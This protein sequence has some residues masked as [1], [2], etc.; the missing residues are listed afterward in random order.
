MITLQTRIDESGYVRLKQLPAPSLVWD[1]ALI[2][3]PRN[4]QVML[5][6]GFIIRVSE[7]GLLLYYEISTDNGLTWTEPIRIFDFG[8]TKLPNLDFYMDSDGIMMRLFFN[9]YNIEFDRWDIWQGFLPVWMFIKDLSNTYFIDGNKMFYNGVNSFNDALK[10]NVYQRNTSDNTKIIQPY[11]KYPTGWTNWEKVG[12]DKLLPVAA[13]TQF[14]LV[15]TDPTINKDNFWMRDIP[16]TGTWTRS[17][18]EAIPLEVGECR[19]LANLPGIERNNAVSF[20]IGT[21]GYIGTGKTETGER[22]NDLWQFDSISGAWKKRAYIFTQREGASAFSIA[23]KGYLVGGIDPDSNILS[24][25]WK[26][27]ET[28]NYWTQ[29]ADIP[30]ARKQAVSFVIDNKAYIATGENGLGNLN[31]LYSYDPLT[32]EWTRKADLPGNARTGA[33]GFSILRKGYVCA[34]DSGSL[35]NDLWEYDPDTDS[36]TAKLSLPASARKNAIGF[37]IGTRGYIALGN[38]GARLNDVWEY[39]QLTNTWIQRLDFAGNAKDFSAVF[40][41]GYAA[42]IGT[43][44][45]NGTD[46]T[47]DLWYYHPRQKREALPSSGNVVTTDGDQVIDTDSNNVVIID[48]S[49]S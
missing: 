31:T 20:S 4:T 41:I 21:K 18:N 1:D 36:W 7:S 22:T 2:Q 10:I 45:E 30:E 49:Y 11:E 46:Y 26:Y 6:G 8:Y 29:V 3:D 13:Y 47:A 17:A 43:G 9:R 27:D 28:N 39:H 23:G 40:V 42:Y 19:I 44:K 14:A 16:A 35:E 32:N 24:D 33:V 37:S 12:T 48:F 38:D 25:M 5:S 34:G 15:I